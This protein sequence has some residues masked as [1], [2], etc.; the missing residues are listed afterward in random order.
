MANE[1]W[2]KSGS[3]LHDL[4]NLTIEIN[5]VKPHPLCC[6]SIMLL[7]LQILLFLLSIVRHS[8]QRNFHNHP[9]YFSAVLYSFSSFLTFFLRQTSVPTVSDSNSG[10]FTAVPSCLRLSYENLNCETHAFSN[11]SRLRDVHNTA[12]N[13]TLCNAAVSHVTSLAFWFGSAIWC[14]KMTS[15]A[16]ITAKEVLVRKQTELLTCLA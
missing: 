9:L 6:F 5:I 13:P 12:C 3:G 15:R 4:A 1:F 10:A 16:Y 2:H 8:G 14:D 11:T 7:P